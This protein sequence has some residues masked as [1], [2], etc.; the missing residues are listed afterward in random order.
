MR[1]IVACAAVMAV[2]V[3]LMASSAIAADPTTIDVWFHGG[4][5][6][7]SET[8]KSQVDAFNAGQS[9]ESRST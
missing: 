6:A 8:F 9:A 1:G 2:T 7:E 3:P 4:L 5:G